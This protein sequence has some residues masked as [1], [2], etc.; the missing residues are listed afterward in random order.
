MG[1]TTWKNAPK[2]RI[3][4]ADV[5]VAKNYLAEEEL[6]TL[7]LIVSQYLEF[8]ELQARS[9]KT[10]TMADWQRKLDDFL[11]L[12]DRD[13]LTHGGRISQ[14]LAQERA[15]AEFDRYEEKRRSIEATE[16][17]SDFDRAVEAMKRLERK[18]ED[19]NT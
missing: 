13:I 2:G 11:R 18:G 15:E 7:N 1:L 16:P 3:R 5:T 19:P 17:T 4:K 9:R 6:F 8:A 10:M 14:K 12:N